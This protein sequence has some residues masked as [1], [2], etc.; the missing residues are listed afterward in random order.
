[1]QHPPTC[2]KLWMGYTPKLRLPTWQYPESKKTWAVQT[3][4]VYNND[5]WVGKREHLRQQNE[6]LELL[7]RE[8]LI[9]QTDYPKTKVNLRQ[10]QTTIG[11]L[12]K[13]KTYLDQ[14]N[15]SYLKGLQE[16]RGTMVPTGTETT[17]G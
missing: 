12:Q 3:G 1:M 11:E 10:V 8:L 2:N 6:Q 4:M 15:Q 5:D 16:V 17:N 13:R 9:V 14:L 7:K